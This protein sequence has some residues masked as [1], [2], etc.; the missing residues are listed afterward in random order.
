MRLNN[1]VI[2]LKNNKIKIAVLVGGPSA[3]HEVSL[4]TGKNIISGLNRDKYLVK[5]VFISKAGKWY[6]LDSFIADNN[7]WNEDKIKSLENSKAY[8]ADEALAKL[9]KDI[10]LAFI[11]MHGEFGEDGQ[12]QGLL[13]K[14]SIVYTG[15]D[16][17]SSKLAMDKENSNKIYNDTGLLVAKYWVIKKVEEIN[18]LDIQMP[19]VIKPADRGSSV[20]TFIIEDINKLNE[21][22]QEA[23][24][25]SSRVMLQEFIAGEE[26]TCSVLEIDARAKALSV[27]LI[28]PKTEF[29]DYEAKYTPGACEEV[30]PAPISD[31]LTRQIQT[32]ALKAHQVLGCSNYSRTDFIIRGD[33]VY[34]LETNTLPGMTGTS[35]LPQAAKACGINFP[36]LLDV[37]IYNSLD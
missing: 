5:P 27:T 20:G 3:E 9:K 24:K 2:M 14:H 32:K 10:D 35:L 16:A 17:K 31:D 29:F 28:K 33:D 21:S 12:V 4:S 36:E 26:V 8:E 37:I 11:A 30:T 25:F 13:E 19:V 34:I 23:L 6:F 1:N 22:I 15:S 7:E 18:A